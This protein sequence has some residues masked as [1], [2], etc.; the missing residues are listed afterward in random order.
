MN[1]QR[2]VIYTKRRNALFGDRLSVDILDAFYSLA[3]NAI[4]L[5]KEDEY[6]DY[7]GFKLYCFQNVCP[8]PF[9]K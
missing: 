4:Q 7:E 6:N 5:Y 2:E 1:L 9:R 3:A 8:E